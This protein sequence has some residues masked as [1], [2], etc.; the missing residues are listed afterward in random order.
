MERGHLKRLLSVLRL[1]CEPL[2]SMLLP[3]NLRP[4]MQT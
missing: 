3:R 2:A 1:T 4:P